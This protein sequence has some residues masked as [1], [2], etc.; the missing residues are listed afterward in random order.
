MDEEISNKEDKQE[1][2]KE[3]KEEEK[4]EE[5]KPKPDNESEKVN[6]DQEKKEKVKKDK[7]EKVKEY[8]NN[9]TD[10]MRKNP[11]IAS[12]FVLGVFMLIIMLT[13][14]S[15]ITGGTVSEDNAGE[16]LLN[17]YESSGAEGLV[18]DSVETE[19]D[20]YK[21]I[22]IYQGKNIPF[23]VTKTG[24]VVGNS[25]VSIIP[26][27]NSNID[28]QTQNDIPKSD[29]PEVELFVMS[30]CPYGNRAENTMLPVYNLLKD[31]VDWNIHYIVSIEGSNINS[32][33]GQPEVEQN[34]REACV[35][36]EYGLIEWWA[37]TTYVNE[38]CGYDGICWEDAAK[39][40]N[41][42]INKI[43]TCVSDNGLNLMKQSEEASNAAGAGGSP[44]FLI[45]G[46][47]SDAIYQYENPEAYKEAI[48]SAFNKP[49][50]ECEEKLEGSSSPSNAGG[51]C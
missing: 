4:T 49:P 27:D 36:N 41:L 33:H 14:F 31:N 30:F 15:G 22:L 38:N 50:Q 47:Q 18:L 29:K 24:Y 43:K 19:G 44:T 7:F 23:Y 11:W 35:L 1:E 46:V 28:S 10:K 48:C 34:E 5:S 9:L 25:L 32:L 51:S 42:D 3:E 6:Q 21:I 20:F 2:E 45:N 39:E 17:F 26:Q 37:F 16:M 12:T 40:A 8:K 13:G